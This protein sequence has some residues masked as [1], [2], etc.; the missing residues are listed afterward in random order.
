MMQFAAA[1]GFTFREK[2]NLQEFKGTLFT[3][4][5]G[6]EAQNV[7]TGNY[8]DCPFTLLNYTFKEGSGKQTR[9]Y[10]VTLAEARIGGSLPNIF[11][12]SSRLLWNGF[13]PLPKRAS[14]T[15]RTF[16]SHPKKVH[17]EDRWDKLFDLY[18]PE[19][20][21][22]EAFQIFTPEVLGILEECYKSGFRFAVE[23]V[24][25]RCYVYLPGK[26]GNAK[27]L[28]AVYTVLGS[29]LERVGPELARMRRGLEAQKA[30][31]S[32]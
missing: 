14:K 16:A 22:A 23:L 30:V 1:N 9:V 10:H 28:N 32:R 27:K 18:A 5:Y 6:R 26:I 25:D 7:V 3:L 20:Y 24:E 8:K 15:T 21:E 17:L 19:D 31:F 12:E 13:R 2:A 29:L 11:L 4:G